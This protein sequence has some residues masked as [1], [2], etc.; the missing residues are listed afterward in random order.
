MKYIIQNNNSNYKEEIDKIICD[1][2]DKIFTFFN[3]LE[4][5]IPC[6]IYIF[7]IV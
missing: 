7:M 4:I 2:K 6:N 5:D 1:N 3:S